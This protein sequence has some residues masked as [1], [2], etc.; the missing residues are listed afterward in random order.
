MTVVGVLPA[1]LRVY[2]GSTSGLPPLVDICF[3]VLRMLV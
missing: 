2:L 1:G 3:R